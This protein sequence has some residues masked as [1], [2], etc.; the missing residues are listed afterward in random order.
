M[1]RVSAAQNNSSERD[2]AVHERSWGV[3]E[4][5][6]VLKQNPLPHF[7]KNS[8]KTV[9]MSGHVPTSAKKCILGCK[10]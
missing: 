8:G 1:A 4:G 9:Q 2:L 7:G 3:E 6:S 5:G 10:Q